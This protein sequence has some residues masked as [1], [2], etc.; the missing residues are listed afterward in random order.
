MSMSEHEHLI[1]LNKLIFVSDTQFHHIVTF[2]AGFRIYFGFP[3]FRFPISDL[4]YKNGPAF[5]FQL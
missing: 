5:F 4:V 1:F 3:D 2:P